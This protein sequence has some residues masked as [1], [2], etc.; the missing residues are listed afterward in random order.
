[1]KNIIERIEQAT[2]KSIMPL[3]YLVLH[4]SLIAVSWNNHDIKRAQNQL[5]L[6][7]IKD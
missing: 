7:F 3:I 2:E 1:M 5:I 4:D 6:N